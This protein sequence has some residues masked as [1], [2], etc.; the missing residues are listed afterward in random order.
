M[1]KK[2]LQT[3]LKALLVEFP[4]MSSDEVLVAARKAGYGTIGKQAIYNARNSLRKE[5]DKGVKPAAVLPMP[6]KLQPEARR[7]W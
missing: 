7:R 5:S 2:P 4:N 3:W 6:P 1:E